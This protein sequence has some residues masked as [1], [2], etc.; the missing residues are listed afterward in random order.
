MTTA[1]TLPVADRA[2]VRRAGGRLVRADKAAFT[3]ALLLNVAAAATGLVSPLVVGRIITTVQNGQGLPTIDRLGV[4]LVVAALAQFV[5]AR[6]ARSVAYR[7]GERTAAR[8]REQF[9]ERMLNLDSHSVEKVPAADL[10]ARGSVDVGAVAGVLRTAAPDV[11][12]ALIQAIIIAAATLW[13]SPIL[14]LCG[15]AGLTAIGFALRWYLRRA[16]PAYLEQSAANAAAATTLAETTDHART[17]AMFG[18]HE[19]RS[20]ALAAA[21]NHTEATMR[22]TLALRSRLFPTIDTSYGIAVAAVVAVGG[23]LFLGG[24]L[25]LGVVVAAALY[26][27]QL[28]APLDTLILWTETLQSAGA[29]FARIEGLA[30]AAPAT[31]TTVDPRVPVDETIALVDVNYAYRPG[32]DVLHA[33][34]LTVAPG[35]RLAIVGTSGAGKTT[36]GRLLAGID[37]PR[38]GSATV[39]GIPLANLPSETLREHVIMVTQDHYV[40][41]DSIR[42]NLALATPNATDDQLTAALRTVGARWLDDLPDGLDT[43]LTDQRYLDGGQAQH[44]ALARVVL[45]NPH[46]VVL[47]EATAL[48]D[49]RTARATERAL[50]AT[51]T[52]RTVVAIAHRLQTA[53]DADHIVVMDEGRISETGTHQDLLAQ[54]GP[55]AQLWSSWRGSSPPKQSH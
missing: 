19:Q 21:L 9:T 46:T 4:I 40:F 29:S 11:L 13:L 45:A 30:A 18:L 50:S 3:I 6:F 39:G 20:Q 53:H 34:S 36:V 31:P 26:I 47:D 51:L 35:A 15:I 44:I 12:F 5:L 54:S 48:L 32:H 24:N 25:S 55:Y 37:T 41:R 2:Q 28:S 27:R 8:L 10:A 16:R 17:I 14:G 22:R 43:E 38:T 1:P 23:A 7:F 52:G 42:N 49:P 33:V